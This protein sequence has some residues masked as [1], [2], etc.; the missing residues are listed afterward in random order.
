MSICNINADMA[1]A[2]LDARIE[3]AKGRGQNT[4]HVFQIPEHELH[5][6][7]NLGEDDLFQLDWLSGNSRRVAEAC[8]ARRLRPAV[9]KPA[10]LKNSYITVTWDSSSNVTDV[11][12][13]VDE[14]TGGVHAVLL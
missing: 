1:I 12:V 4:A 11:P 8:A 3:E 6:P 10:W 13:D 14:T 5:A 9:F 7:S 2:G